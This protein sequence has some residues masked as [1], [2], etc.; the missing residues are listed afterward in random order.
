MKNSSQ[1]IS[2]ILVINAKTHR[3]HCERAAFVYIPNLKIIVRNASCT[4]LINWSDT[5]NEWAK[6]T[7][8]ATKHRVP[9]IVSNEKQNERRSALFL[10][11]W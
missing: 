6:Q 7:G 5:T 2:N 8:Q 3:V 10:S 4:Y 11:I 9:E 1:T